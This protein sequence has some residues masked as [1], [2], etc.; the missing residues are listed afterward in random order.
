MNRKLFSLLSMT[1]LFLFLVGCNFSTST[2]VTPTSSTGSTT[3]TDIITTTSTTSLTTT[4]STVTT[5]PT[6]TQPSIYQIFYDLG[7]GVNDNRNPE[8]Y[9]S[10]SDA[11][12]IY[13]PTKEGYVFTGWTISDDQQPIKEV[14]I[15]EGTSGDITLKAHW[16]DIQN[17]NF[18][19]YTDPSEE[20][21]LID[22]VYFLEI[23]EDQTF[24]LIT[25][26]LYSD[27]N[28]LFESHY[29]VLIQLF[30]FIYEMRFDQEA[31]SKYI[32]ID[33]EGISF[34]NSD[35]TPIESS[36]TEDGRLILDPSLLINDFG[37]GYFDLSYHT[38][39]N[40]MQQLYKDIFTLSSNF[41]ISDYD[42]DETNHYLLGSVDFGSYGL[43]FDEAIKV[44][45]VFLLD[46]PNHYW[47]SNTFTGTDQHLNLFIHQAYLS[48][49]KRFVINQALDAM[50]LEVESLI[51]PHHNELEISKIIHDFVIQRIDYA[52]EDDGITPKDTPWAH[53][54]EGVVLG[55]GAVCEGYA[56][57]F[58]ILLDHF[59]IYNLLVT[60]IS[61]NQNHMWNL[62]RID[63]LFYHYDLTWN[64]PGFGLV[65]YTYMG[66]NHQS[67]SNTHS[68]DNY[69][70]DYLRYIYQLPLTSEHNITMVELIE[71]GLSLGSYV[72]I[73]KAMDKMTDLDGNYEL[74]LFD[75]D[76][77]GPLLMSQSTRTYEL[78]SGEWPEVDQI[79]FIG[80]HINMGGGYYAQ[81]SVH[82]SGDITVNS[83]LE[84]SDVT[85]YEEAGERTLY[86][87]NHVLMFSGY[88]CDVH[89]SHIIGTVDSKIQSLISRLPDGLTEAQGVIFWST[90]I[91]VSALDLYAGL[92]CKSS[93]CSF[94]Q[95]NIFGNVGLILRGYQPILNVNQMNIY[96]EAVTIVAIS[97]A[98]N[99]IV[100]LDQ[101]STFAENA[102][103]YGITFQ[104]VDITH[105]P[106]IN[107]YGT[108]N[109]D[110][111]YNFIDTIFTLTTDINGNQINYDTFKVDF[112]LAGEQV[113]IHAPDID[114]SRFEIRIAD[115]FVTGLFTQNEE[116]GI[117]R[118]KTYIE[119]IVDGVLIE[120]I[121]IN[122]NPQNTYIVPNTVTT[123]GIYALR[124]F[125]NLTEVVISD[126][127]TEIQGWA[128]SNTKYLKQVVIPSSVTLIRNYA[129]LGASLGILFEANEL[130]ETWETY[131][132]EGMNSIIWGYKGPIVD[133]GEFVYTITSND[134]AIILALSESNAN[135]D[136]VIPNYLEGYPV[137][138]FMIE[139]FRH[140]FYITSVFIPNTIVKIPE[141]AFQ[142]NYKLVSVIFESGSNLTTIGRSAFSTCYSLEEIYIPDSVT[143]AGMYLFFGDS[144]VTIY[145]S[146]IT[147]TVGWN[148][149]WNA[150]AAGV[151][152]NVI[153]LD[154]IQ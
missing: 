128:F 14:V 96:S 73:E 45:K 104:V 98:E 7:N 143:Y 151:V 111:E 13:E 12:T 79:T 65:S 67:I 2:T 32:K 19:T 33:D 36:S 80:K 29:G 112:R 117:Y 134:V 121:S 86:I 100:H 132:S 21:R 3:N 51:E 91:D 5:E 109:F 139:T 99:A 102:N 110:I 118:D 48:Y 153:Y 105:L 10:N 113:I 16:F 148:S 52:Y 136:I 147:Q 141:Y 82:M 17:I 49:A 77:V 26:Y 84:F 119:T 126:S 24:L 39:G 64:D 89:I 130:P 124:G 55:Y 149:A 59:G 23:S 40:Q 60:G 107:I 58:K 101:L 75:Y 61:N 138:E 66:L 62:V 74:V 57:T 63:G 127:V 68:I 123:I 34:C 20:V 103:Y 69:Q 150:E 54:F 43:S 125:M 152:P 18:N 92:S 133:N 31:P 94:D 42:S 46:F 122:Y 35:G 154:E 137:I 93:E 41:G 47:L 38:H 30:G 6:T 88:Q 28:S 140:N 108:P 78:P 81:I 25:G 76:R 37:Y 22:L 120:V 9:E 116:G 129:F 85:I 70:Y 8:T 27:G 95:V 44:M 90:D 106:I 71:N 97:I 11:I 72:S 50:I 115:I 87:Q 4:T 15:S 131:W 83:S 1:V 53:N 145:I 114:I 56:E 135:L 142:D 144:L 146:S